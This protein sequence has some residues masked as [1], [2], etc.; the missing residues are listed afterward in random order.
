ML[1]R[2]SEQ[3]LL[4]HDAALIAVYEAT[5]AFCRSLF[6]VAAKKAAAV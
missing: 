4:S 3:K 2:E 6:V 5:Y 1:L